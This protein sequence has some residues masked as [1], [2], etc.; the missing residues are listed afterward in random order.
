MATA[1]KGG[2]ISGYT[3]SLACLMIIGS[4]IVACVEST[5]SQIGR[6][7]LNMKRTGKPGAGKPR[8]GKY[9]KLTPLRKRG[10]AR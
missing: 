1:G 5:F 6:I 8:A 3:R 2:V 7:N 4:N 9:G 10:G